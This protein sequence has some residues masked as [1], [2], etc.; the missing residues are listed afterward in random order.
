MSVG[1]GAIVG[2]GERYADSMGV[3]RN[4]SDHAT[5]ACTPL[6]SQ[7]AFAL[8]RMSAG[9]SLVSAEASL[10]TSRMSGFRAPGRSR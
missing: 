6:P 1:S 5:G 3:K 10:A 2:I 8:L 7:W 4:T 9:P